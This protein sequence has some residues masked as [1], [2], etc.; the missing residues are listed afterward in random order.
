MNGESFPP[1]LVIPAELAEAVRELPIWFVIGGQAV[2]CF[3]PYRPSRDVDFGVRDAAGLDDLLSQ[4]GRTGRLE[5]SERSEDTAHL[6]WNG[7]DVS[8]FVLPF[9]LPYVAER[10]LAATRT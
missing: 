2:R 1:E 7:I 8:I 10:H 4:L 5:L 9:L 3:C 6:R